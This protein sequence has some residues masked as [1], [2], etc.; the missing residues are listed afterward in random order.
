M[1]ISQRQLLRNIDDDCTTAGT[2]F[3]NFGPVTSEI[4]W[5]VCR[6]WVGWVQL[7]KKYARLRY[8]YWS[9]WTDTPVFILFAGI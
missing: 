1:G 3:V 5:R 4:L 8:F 7:A 6:R 9:F 2:N